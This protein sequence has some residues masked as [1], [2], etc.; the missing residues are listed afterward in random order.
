MNLAVVV[1]IAT[2]LVLAT[3]ATDAVAGVG[4]ADVGT[5]DV[6]T[7]AS[8]T[9]AA[10]LASVIPG[11]TT[12]AET[13][14]STTVSTAASAAAS[15]SE[16]ISLSDAIERALRLSPAAVSTET[17]ISLAKANQLETR[18]SWLPSVSATAGYTKSS[19]ERVDS[20]TGRLTSE[21]YTAGISSSLVLFQG[22]RR[23]WQ[24]RST[25]AL[26]S[27]A[28]ADH[29]GQVFDTIL[30]TT[31]AFYE[32]AAASD[33]ELLARQRLE[34]A[35]QQ[36]AFAETRIE[37]GTA[38]R[39]DVLR[40]E[41]EVGN[42]ELAVLDSESA[43][44]TAALQLG[45]LVGTASEVFPDA[46]SLPGAAPELPSVDR[47][48]T[49]AESNS[50][51]VVSREA[52]LRS[53]QA[54]RLTAVS[55]Y[56]PSVGLTAG[57]DWFSPDFPPDRR[58]WNVRLSASLPIFDRFGRE[59]SVQ[60]AKASLRRAEATAR[61][62]LIA[63]RVEVE[64]AVQDVIAAGQRVTI[65]DRARALA[66]E[67]LRVL[68]ERYQAEAATILD[69]QASQVALTEAEVGTVRARQALG[70]AIARL[71]AVLGETIEEA[72]GE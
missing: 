66:E 5:A 39:S 9:T 23:L 53:A 60:R 17:A 71:E 37:V 35:R 3:A 12:S 18:G 19:D 72:S 2:A 67:D 51:L 48:V 27:A 63:A 33:L 43:L 6:A 31:T 50:P 55:T 21:S 70:T 54:S 32:A 29:R 68:E 36:L 42:A 30:E 61:D 10:T 62:A 14:A 44:R 38:T 45:R 49:R 15:I 28:E 56:L 65:S 57:Y 69:L 58:T 59:A 46:E 11:S 47:L 41:L 1:T 7:P 4:A 26:V 8:T 22:G 20:S 16:T 13:S 24:N 25:S 52:E 34:R 64:S 40:A